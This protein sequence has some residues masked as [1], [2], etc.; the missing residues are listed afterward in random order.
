MASLK[1]VIPYYKNSAKEEI[2]RM[3]DELYNQLLVQV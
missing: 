1:C 3:R 2:K